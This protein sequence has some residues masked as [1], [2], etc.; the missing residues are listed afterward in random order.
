[1]QLT[2]DARLEAYRD[3]RDGALAGEYGERVQEVAVKVKERREA[4]RPS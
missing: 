4:C 3:I 1:M 2:G